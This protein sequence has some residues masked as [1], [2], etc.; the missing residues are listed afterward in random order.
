MNVQL[1]VCAAAFIVMREVIKK[2]TRRDR[3]WW[4]S[5]MY[6]NNTDR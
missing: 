6:K 2:N 5:K 4:I 1:Q 3:R